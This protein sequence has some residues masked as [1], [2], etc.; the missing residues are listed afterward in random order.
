MAAPQLPAPY[1]R[2]CGMDEKDL[3]ALLSEIKGLAL[4][5]HNRVPGPVT[6]AMADMLLT[7]GRIAGLA[8]RVLEKAREVGQDETRRRELNAA[9]EAARKELRDG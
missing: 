8:D 4:S 5:A 1:G 3:A 2:N 9:I 6:D 7:L